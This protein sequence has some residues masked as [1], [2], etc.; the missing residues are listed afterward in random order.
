MTD[1]EIII[2]GVN[3]AGCGAYMPK[4]GKNDCIAL[5]NNSSATCKGSP[6]CYLKQCQRKEQ[7]CEEYKAQAKK[8]LADYFEENKKC[9][10]LKR[11]NVLLQN[12][13]QQLDGAITEAASYKQALEKIEEIIHNKSIITYEIRD[14]KTILNE[15]L[16]C[17]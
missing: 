17:N 9:K 8:Y 13:N 12:H 11:K 5:G 10:E 14:I 15:V 6:N 4:L 3:V 16:K 1:K 7:E 2:D